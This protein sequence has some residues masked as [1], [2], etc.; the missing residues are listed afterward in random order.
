M[1]DLVQPQPDDTAQDQTIVG[2][3]TPAQDVRLRLEGL[4]SGA[5]LELETKRSAGGRY[6]MEYLSAIALAHSGEPYALDTNT[7]ARL[8]L[9]TSTGALSTE[10]LRVMGDAFM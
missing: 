7:S 10:D 2:A 4:A 5:D 9:V 8:D 1:A 3:A 6:D